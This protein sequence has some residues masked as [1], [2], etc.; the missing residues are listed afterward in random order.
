MLAL[1]PT[2]GR[3][4]QLGRLIRED[5]SQDHASVLEWTTQ[6][7]NVEHGA[8]KFSLILATVGRS[9]D[10]ARFLQHLERQTYRNFELIVVDQNQDGILDPL[11]RQHK[12]KF[13]LLHLRSERGLSRARNVGLQHFSGDVVAF[14]DDDCWYAPETLEKVA[15]AFYENLNCDGFTGRGVDDS[16]PADYI[17]FSRQSGLINKKNVWR[18]GISY[19]IF[20]RANVVRVVRPF[21]ESL[22]VGSGSGKYSAEET[23]Y[24]IRA[25]N[26][27]FRI[28][29]CTDLCIFHRHPALNYDLALIK[30]SYGYSVGFGYVLRKHNYPIS[31]VVYCWLRALGGAAVSLFTFNFAKSRFHFAALKGRVLGWL[32]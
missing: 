10:L 27:R 2:P 16:R 7:N 4:R 20:L 28:Q 19:A 26:S 13:P 29:Y 24:L 15:R 21:D 17:S 9:E 25:I 12:E 11:I 22:G 5:S 1:H 18:R 32:G 6:E 30:K 14:P 23:D 8:I 31:F 3:G